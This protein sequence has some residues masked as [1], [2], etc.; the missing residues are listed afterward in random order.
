MPVTEINHFNLRTPYETMLK[1]KDFY[2]DVVGLKVGPR[3]GFS[4]CGFWLYIGDNDVLHL[5]EYR[6]DGEPL[7]HVLTSVDHFSFTCTDMPAMEAHLNACKVDYTVRDLP[8]LK[9]KQINFK[10][11]V[12]NGIELFFHEA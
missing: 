10:D 9:V 5:A 1:L 4:S 6:G 8:V 2:C 3:Q 12:G 7:S 11:P